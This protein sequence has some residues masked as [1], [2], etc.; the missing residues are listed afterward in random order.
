MNPYWSLLLLAAAYATLEKRDAS[1]MKQQQDD[2]VWGSLS[3]RVGLTLKW[4]TCPCFLL[5]S[6]QCAS[7]AWSSWWGN[8]WRVLPKRELQTTWQWKAWN[9]MIWLLK[10]LQTSVQLLLS[11]QI[12][13]T[14]CNA[15]KHSMTNDKFYDYKRRNLRHDSL[16][17]NQLEC[18]FLYDSYFILF[19]CPESSIGF[20]NSSTSKLLKYRSDSIRP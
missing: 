12:A 17:I 19:I 7:S 5:Y 2:G 20:L 6:Y 16:W 9:V 8:K 15:Q 14:I 4:G 18:N 11:I 1:I 3:S 10:S 13:T